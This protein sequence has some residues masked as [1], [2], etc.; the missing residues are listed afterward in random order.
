MTCMVRE[1]SGTED[2]KDYGI[3]HKTDQL[4]PRGNEC[5]QGN[6]TQLFYRYGNVN[7]KLKLLSF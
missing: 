1:G 4:K 7:N 6:K 2:G 5:Y 3:K